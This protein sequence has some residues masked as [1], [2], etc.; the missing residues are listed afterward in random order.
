MRE[1]K[2]RGLGVESRGW[3]Y[4]DLV[5]GDGYFNI[6]FTEI[7]D[8]YKIIKSC[9][10]ITDSVGQFIGLSDQ[11]FKYIYE[12]DIVSY[13]L[14]NKYENISHG[15]VLFDVKESTYI[16][17]DNIVDSYLSKVFGIVVVGNI[18]ENK[19]LLLNERN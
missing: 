10:V 15:I 6:G 11:N 3:H 5:T 12:G 14:D 19:D 4:G 7:H 1:I 9:V 16:I 8:G 2:F 13:S 17:R 18:H